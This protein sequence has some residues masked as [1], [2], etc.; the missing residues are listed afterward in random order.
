M[1]SVKREY[2]IIILTE[3]T[4]P[5]HSVPAVMFVKDLSVLTVAVS[6]WAEILSGAV[7]EKH[8]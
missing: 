6:A 3:L 2:S 7:N 8:R 1:L 5:V 4:V